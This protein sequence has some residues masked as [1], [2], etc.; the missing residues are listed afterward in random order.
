MSPSV[1]SA[2]LVACLGSLVFAALA[3]RERWQ[4][5]WFERE[6]PRSIAAFR[7]VFAAL[8][9]LNVF[10]LRRWFSY[11]FTA[12]GLLTTLE[13]REM[14]AQGLGD[15]GLLALARGVLLGP[16]S[17]LY[18]VD[19]FGL[20]LALFVVSALLLLI[21]LWTRVAGVLTLLL[22]NAII[23]RNFVF[24]EGTELVLRVLLVYLVCARC[25]QAYSVDR[26]L[27]RRRA[28]VEEDRFEYTPIPAWPRKLIMVQVVALMVCTGLLKHGGAWIDG[29]AVYY[30]LT[31]DRYARFRLEPTLALI[32]AGGL[33]LLTWFART[34]EVLLP[35]V[36]A[37]IVARR[38]ALAMSTRRRRL[39]AGALLVALLSSTAIV[40]GTGAP[41]VLPS[42]SPLVAAA[43][44]AVTLGGAW[45]LGALARRS[46][47]GFAPRLARL[48]LARRVWITAAAVLMLGMWGLMHIGLFHPVMLAALIPFFDGREVGAFVDRLCRRRAATAGPTDRALAYTPAVRGALGVLIGWHL[49]ALTIAALP[50]TGP[51]AAVRQA[52]GVAVGPWLAATRTM[53]SW[54]MWSRVPREMEFLKVVVIDA[55][56]RA[57]DLRSDLYAEELRPPAPFGYDRW[58]KIAGRIVK[59]S[60]GSP[61]PRAHARWVCRHVRPAPVTVELWRVTYPTPTPTENR[62][63]GGSDF[64]AALRERGSEARVH[65]ETCDPASAQT[66]APPTK[67]PR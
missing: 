50:T 64:S 56:G 25:G 65:V 18:F 52:A 67:P 59:A 33:A 49:F 23:T 4:A 45:W 27:R 2:L 51:T 26:W 43:S 1:A 47:P 32:G 31:H 34:V 61:W 63:A 6:D 46:G 3:G 19:A 7:V 38:P 5:W 62:Q 41:R 24:W 66:S 14:F 10:G 11:L 29:D 16:C 55:E 53:Q 58:W 44:W 21:G 35:L 39:L 37:G 57:R 9:L 60:D 20:V 15:G 13:A 42:S 30:A 48:V 36:L 12:D 40:Y 8:L 54:G 28:R 22:F 17:A